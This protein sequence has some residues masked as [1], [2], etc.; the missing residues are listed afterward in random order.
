MKAISP[1][2]PPTSGLDRFTK[3]QDAVYEAVLSELRSGQKRTHWMWFIFP[4]IAGLGL[5]PTARFFAI[6]SRA[7]AEAYL[8]HDVLGSRLRECVGIMMA[9]ERKTAHEILGS[10]DDIK[11]RSCL[12]LFDAISPKGNPFAAALQRFYQGHPD[13]KTLVLLRSSSDDARPDP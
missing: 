4:Q 11:F 2:R 6:A 7:E 3:A 13:V 8:G 1:S 12:T 5:S 9:Q 10:P